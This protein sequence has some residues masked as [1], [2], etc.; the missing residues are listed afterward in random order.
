MADLLLKPLERLKPQAERAN[1]ALALDLPA[2]LPQALADPERVHQIV[3]NLLHNAIKFTPEGGKITLEA[4]QHETEAAVVIAVH[5]SGIGIPKE[6][7]GRIFERFYK[8]DRARTRGLG[9]NRTWFGYLAAHGGTAQ[10][11][12]FGSRAR[13]IK[14]AASF[15]PSPLAINQFPSAWHFF[16]LKHKLCQLLTKP[17]PNHS[18]SLNKPY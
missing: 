4:Y 14:A 11:P 7:L 10:R 9:G 2:G 5:D 3:T 18:Q 16:P 17:L 6:D 8:S 12:V 13:N 15:S 1:I